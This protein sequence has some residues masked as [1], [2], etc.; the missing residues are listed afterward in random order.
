M[1]QNTYD[2]VITDDDDYSG[3][4]EN[5]YTPSQITNWNQGRY[6]DTHADISNADMFL[7]EMSHIIDLFRRG[8]KKRLLKPEYGYTFGPMT[9]DTIRTEAWVMALQNCLCYNLFGECTY[10]YTGAK[11]LELFQER[12]PELTKEKWY[13]LIRA[14]EKEIYTSKLKAFYRDWQDACAF[15]K[16]N[17]N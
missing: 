13:E 10:S 17:R 3:V 14:A 6:V 12:I 7:H 16:A 5:I 8:K 1:A 4:A 9:I 15:V 11:S 2:L